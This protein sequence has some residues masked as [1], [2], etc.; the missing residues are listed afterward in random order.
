M[1]GGAFSGDP[2]RG[3][4]EGALSWC[5]EEA[6]SGDTSRTAQE[7]T[8]EGHVPDRTG[9]SIGGTCPGR[10]TEMGTPPSLLPGCRHFP[11]PPLIAQGCSRA[12]PGLRDSNL[13]HCCPPRDAAAPSMAPPAL[14]QGGKGHPHS[15][16]DLPRSSS[17]A[18]PLPL[19]PLCHHV[20][21]SGFLPNYS[22]AANDASLTELS[23]CAHGGARQ[24]PNPPSC[25]ADNSRQ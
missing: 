6:A 13:P 12:A 7:E 15:L 22:S 8:S 24:D 16:A 17:P 25:L 2:R 10:H 18:A 9:D 3:W 5:T 11:S 1:Q 4:G 14:A 20:L 23:L 21:L 19:R